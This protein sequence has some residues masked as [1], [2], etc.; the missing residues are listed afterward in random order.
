[1]IPDELPADVP[2]RRKRPTSSSTDDVE[3]GEKMKMELH[4]VNI[5]PQQHNFFDIARSFKSYQSIDIGEK[6]EHGISFAPQRLV[7]NC[8]I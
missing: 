2:A 5:R 1:M 4:N 7:P 6:C 3:R 8:G